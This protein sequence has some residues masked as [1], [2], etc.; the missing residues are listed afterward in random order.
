MK[1]YELV[2]KEEA[3]SEISSAYNWYENKSEG[4]GERFLESLENCFNIISTQPT[5]FQKIYKKQRQAIVHVFPY[6]V[7]YQKDNNQV[8][9][10]AVFNTHQEVKKKLRS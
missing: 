10:F 2:I 9:V 4:L 5:I 1:Q 3:Q 8:I 6:V 7:M